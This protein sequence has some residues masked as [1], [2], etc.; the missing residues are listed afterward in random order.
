MV[1]KK[2]AGQFQ[3]KTWA[4]KL[5]LRKKLV[6]MKLSDSGSMREYIKDNEGTFDE[7][8]AIAEPITD[9]D[10]VV[11]LL[12]GLPD[13]YDVL[14]TALE[15]GSDAVLALEIVTEHLFREEQKLKDKEETD[16]SKRLLVVKG[17]KQFTCHYCKKPGHFKKD[18]R[19]FALAQLS[20]KSESQKKT[21]LKK[22]RQSSQDAMLVGN[23]LVAAKSRHDWIGDSGAISHICNDQSVFTELKQL[24]KNREVTIGDGSTLNVME[25]EQWI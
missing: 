19:K 16:G 8:A 2:L 17:K 9:E 13:T 25:K 3:K 15:S 20:D 23:A 22:R 11:Y 21:Q 24:D 14:V 4:N 7:L 5:S 10:K 6:T 12:A 1:W 18:C